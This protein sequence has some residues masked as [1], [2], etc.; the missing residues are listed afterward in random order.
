MNAA[1][2]KESGKGR[3]FVE[4]VYRLRVAGLGLGIFCVASVLAQQDR[5]FLMWA[6]LVFHGFVWPHVARRAALASAVPYRGERVNLLIDSVLG[7]FWVAAMRFNVLPSVLI[8]T[9]LSMDNIAAGGL[10]LFNWGVVAHVVGLAAGL[11]LLGFAFEPMSSMPTILACLPFMVIYPIAL[12]W[13]TYRIS[14]KLADQSRSLERLSRTDGLTGILNRR[15]W[16]GVLAHEFERSLAS[17]YASSLLLVD[18]DHFKNLNDTRGHTAG[19]AALQAFAGILREHFRDGGHIGRYGGEEFGIVLP[20]ATLAQARAVAERLVATVREYASRDDAVC[21]CTA[22]VGV[23]QCDEAMRD[24]ISWLQK[25]DTSL[26]A[27]KV[28]G[29][30]RVVVAHAAPVADD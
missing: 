6:L 20:G 16:E 30:D 19:D 3:R 14:R 11:L 8:L 9:M 24:H 26:Y 27:A 4:R 13:S 23:A 18:L 29:R 10:M 15:T 5:G 17:G 1:A 7:G 12:G 25:A 22:S 21:P 2:N 28:A